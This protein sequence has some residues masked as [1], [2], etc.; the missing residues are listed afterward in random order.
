[1]KLIKG[2]LYRVH[3]ASLDIYINR[4]KYTCEEYSKVA[5]SFVK[6]DNPDVVFHFIR[7]I[8]LYHNKIAHWKR[9]K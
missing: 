3:G 5:L 7:N 4:I 2:G 8:K 6:K 1:M 9:I